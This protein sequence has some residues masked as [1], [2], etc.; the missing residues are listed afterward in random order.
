MFPQNHG[1]I[2]CTLPASRPLSA[3]RQ[4]YPPVYD[5]VRDGLFDRRADACFCS[6]QDS[7]REPAGV[8]LIRL[9]WEVWR[10]SS[11]FFS[12]QP[13][14]SPVS[15]SSFSVPRYALRLVPDPASVSLPATADVRPLQHVCCS[16]LWQFAF[17]SIY[18]DKCFSTCRAVFHDST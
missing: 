13:V 17:P 7:D 5:S 16:K 8:R 14:P 9:N 1:H 4:Q 6:G 3:R 15:G 12:P 10:N 11:N 2:R 18:C